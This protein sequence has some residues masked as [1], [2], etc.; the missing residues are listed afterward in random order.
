MGR[1]DDDGNP[2][3]RRLVPVA[4]VAGS[5]FFALQLPWEARMLAILLL[6]SLLTVPGPQALEV[7]PPAGPADLLLHNGRVVTM[8][9]P[10]PDPAPTALA[11]RDGRIVWVGDDDEIRALEGPGTRSIDLRGGVIVPGL[12][13]GHAHLYGIGKALAEIDVRALASAEACA[14][15]VVAAAARQPDGWLQGRGWDQNL[16]PDQSW[17]TRDM[18]DRAMPDRP[19][20]L[21]RVDGHAAW[22][23]SEA[24]RR[25]GITAE[26]P[27]PAGG[28]ILRDAQG[29][30]TGILIDNAADLVREIIPA[31]GEAETER[32]IRLAMEHCVARG[33]TGIHEMGA[34]WDRVQ[35]YRRLAEQGDLLLRV[36]V[37]L[38]DDPATIDAGLAAGPYVSADRML[39]L[40]GI[41]LYADGALGSRGALLLEPYSDRPATRGLAVTGRD[42]LTDVCRRARAGGFQVA[43]HAIGDGANRLM[44]D[45]YADVLGPDGGAARWRIEHAQIVAEADVPRFGQQGVIASMQPTHCTSDMDWAED[46]LG[47]DRLVGAYAWRTLLASD[48]VLSFGSDAPVEAV[49]PV[50][51]LFAACTRTHA[52]G[53]PP[54]GWR[55]EERLDG[56]EALRA[57]TLGPA[58]ASF[59]DDDLGVLAPGWRADITVLSA[60]PTQIAADELLSVE[61]LLT[62]VEGRVVWQAP[63]P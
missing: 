27:D 7:E 26:T 6:T 1:T 58:Y 46:R 48:A 31:P 23:N 54:G 60:D 39:H 28:E 30:P 59:T 33:L 56:R 52:D 49:D 53:M 32:R 42:H 43:T 55:P 35:I 25:A 15:R 12:V 22:V 45:V 17:P 19:V 3:S 13:D 38:E 18:L 9:E 14:A 29:E 41:K 40:R 2:R 16:W 24:L 50:P 21:R 8:L 4:V 44:L 20:M 36:V 61:P 47:P 37:F 10:E 62:V 51:G 63:A 5:T 11:V 57:F 34:K